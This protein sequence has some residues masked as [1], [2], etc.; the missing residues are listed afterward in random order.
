MHAPPQGAFAGG[1]FTPQWLLDECTAALQ[2]IASSGKPQAAL[3]A[4]AV[5]GL[6]AAF[7]ACQVRLPHSPAAC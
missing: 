7:G 5:A 2:R 1:R 3:A 6:S 4:G